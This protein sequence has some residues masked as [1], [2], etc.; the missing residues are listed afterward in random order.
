[1]DGRTDGRTYGWKYKRVM[2]EWMQCG[3]LDRSM[4]EELLIYREG[5]T[6]E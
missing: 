2:D 1:M 4:D 3:L 5:K 6:D